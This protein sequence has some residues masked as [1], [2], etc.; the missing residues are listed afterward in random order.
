V[1]VHTRAQ[2]HQV[3]RGLADEG[4]IVLIAS[5][6]LDELC[7]VADRAVVFFHG[8]IVEEIRRDLDPHLLLEAINTGVVAT[9]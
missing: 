2:M 3:I 6:D 1:D 9:P 5:S 8:R 4:A 7:E